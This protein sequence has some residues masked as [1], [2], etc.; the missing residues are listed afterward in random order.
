VIWKLS[1]QTL[2]KILERLQSLDVTIF[3]ADNWEAYAELILSERLVQTKVQTHGW[4][5]I[6]FVSNL[7]QAILLE[8]LYGFYEFAMIG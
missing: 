7:M 4:S 2:K 8:N 5:R 3:F 6:I 1:A